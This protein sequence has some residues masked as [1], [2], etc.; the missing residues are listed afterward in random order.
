MS[1]SFLSSSVAVPA[2]F[3]RMVVTPLPRRRGTKLPWVGEGV[4]GRFSTVCWNSMFMNRYIGLVLIT[5]ARAGSFALALKCWCTQL[6]CTIAT[7][8]AFQS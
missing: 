1:T 5:K 4:F 8:P 7:S 2:S 3:G 6:L